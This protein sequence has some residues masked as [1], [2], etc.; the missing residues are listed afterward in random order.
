MRLTV[1]TDYT[2]RVMMYLALKFEE[3]GVVTIDEIAH[4]YR[5]PRSHLTKIVNELSQHGFI[6]TTRGRSGGARLARQPNQISVGAMV[7]MA[8]KDFAAVEC[9]D[10]GRELTC[11]IHPVCNL[12]NGIR[13]AVDAFLYE[14][15]KMTLADT[16]TAPTVASSLFQVEAKG[17]KEFLVPVSALQTQRSKT[18]GKNTVALH[19]QGQR[20]RRRRTPS[21]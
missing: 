20:S 9:H 10:T 1:Y 6:E 5:I 8:E 16:I 14:L 2:L 15:D 13:R 17:G 4:A 3:G 11:A 7:R 21:S 12:K 18:A 19:A